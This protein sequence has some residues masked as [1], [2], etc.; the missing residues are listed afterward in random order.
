MSRIVSKKLN[1]PLGTVVLAYKSF[2]DNIKENIENS[3]IINTSKDE[4]ISYPLSYSIQFLGKLY[5][6]KNRIIAINN[7]IKNKRERDETIKSS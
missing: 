2:W 6:H 1:I 4:D 5:T 7:K 3:D